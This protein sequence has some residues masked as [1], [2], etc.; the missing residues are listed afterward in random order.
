MFKKL[1]TIKNVAIFFIVIFITFVIASNI[2]L[3]ITN[4]RLDKKID[5]M[6]EE[7]NTFRN[8]FEIN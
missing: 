6:T 1:K 2:F 3:I 8:S 4:I 7:W 5:N